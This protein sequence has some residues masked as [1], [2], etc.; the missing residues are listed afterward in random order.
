MHLKEKENTQMSIQGTLLAPQKKVIA[1]IQLLKVG[2]FTERPDP[3]SW[4]I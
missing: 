1:R 2:M 4:R 3:P